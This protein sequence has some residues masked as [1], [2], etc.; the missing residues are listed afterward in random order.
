MLKTQLKKNLAIFTKFF[1]TTDDW[2]L[3]NPLKS[4]HFLM[5]LF[6]F[7]AQKFQ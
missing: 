6:H 2:K 1:L 3:K 5:F 4:F 7:V